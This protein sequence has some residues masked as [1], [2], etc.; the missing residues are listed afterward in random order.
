VTLLRSLTTLALLSLSAATAGAV[1]TGLP[2][3]SVTDGIGFSDHPTFPDAELSAMQAGGCAFVRTDLTWRNV[4]ST[5]G[6]YDFSGFNDTYARFAARGIRLLYVLDYDNPLYGTNLAST[7]F[8]NGF[9]NFAAAAAAN[10]KGEGVDFEIWNEPNTGGYTAMQNAYTY[11]NLV[12]KA[13]PAIR[14]ADPTA[15]ILGPALSNVGSTAQTWLQSCCGYGLLNYVDAVSVHTYADTPEEVVPDYAAV[16]SLITQ[17]HP[18]GSIPIVSSEVGWSLTNFT[19]QQQADYMARM[20]LVNFSQGIPLSCWYTFKDGGYDIT[21]REWN[22]G[23]VT[24]DIQAKPAYN[25]L[26]L[27]TASLKGTTFSQK[28]SD[29][30][31]A[32]WLLEFTLPSGQKTLAAWTTGSSPVDVT[33]SGWG[34]LHLTSTPFY[35]NPT[36]VAGDASLDGTVNFTDLNVV[37]TNY[38]LAGDW[39]KGDFNHDGLVNFADLNI[40]LTNYN[41]SY[42]ASAVLAYDGLDAAAMQ[43]LSLAG[44]TVVPEP[45]A[46]TTLALGLVGLLVYARR[47]R[48]QCQFMAFQE[49]SL[50]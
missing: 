4:E 36:L 25:K 48:R 10:F 11:V 12:K 41:H 19:A 1:D 16:K 49:D 31:S 9:A 20:Y 17:Y 21:N 7:T 32:D 24:P 50:A 2:S 40:V 3:G 39:M 8:R 43:A 44:V 34:A 18:S 30:N 28:L 26:K 42:G 37:L 27:L 13:A 47:G 23:I 5:Q 33:V 15:A 38:N 6:I 29:G 46:I 22:F 14:A 45:A 35:V